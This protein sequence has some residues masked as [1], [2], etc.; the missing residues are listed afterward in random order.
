MVKVDNSVID[1]GRMVNIGDTAVVIHRARVA[2]AVD[3]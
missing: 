2:D 1:S 3:S